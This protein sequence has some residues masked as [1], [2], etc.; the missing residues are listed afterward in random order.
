MQRLHLKVRDLP[1]GSLYLFFLQAAQ[2]VEE[3][4]ALGKSSAATL[5]VHRK[6]TIPAARDAAEALRPASMLLWL[7]RW[8]SASTWITLVSTPSRCFCGRRP[9]GTLKTGQ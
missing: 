1:R 4:I 8:R 2:D 5:H 3:E 7:L 9:R 6:A